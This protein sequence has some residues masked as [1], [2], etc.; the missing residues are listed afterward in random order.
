MSS[1]LDLFQE[2]F[3]SKLPEIEYEKLSDDCYSSD[4]RI[5]GYPYFVQNDCI[6]FDDGDFLL[7]QLDIDEE[8]G[9]MFGDSGNCV[10]SIP[11]DA[12]KNR[13]FTK[14]V[15]DWQCC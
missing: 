10:F 4:S 2:I 13:D 6:G 5:G 3:M 14:V 8:C 7:L 12:L 9:I 15:Y 11:K 1:S